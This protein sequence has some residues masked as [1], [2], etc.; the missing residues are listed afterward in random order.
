MDPDRYVKNSPL[1]QVKKVQTP[2]MIVNVTDFTQ[3]RAVPVTCLCYSSHQ[4][5]LGR[6]HAY[7]G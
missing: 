3:A 1:F 7:A 6:S 5:I 2:G 4:L